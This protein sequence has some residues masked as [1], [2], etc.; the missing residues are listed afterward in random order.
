MATLVEA[1][2]IESPRPIITAAPPPRLCTPLRDIPFR[3]LPALISNP[4]HPP[5][6]GFDDPHAGID[7]AVMLPDSQVAIAGHPVQAALSGRVAMLIADRF[8]FGNALLIETPLD[9]Q[10]EDW[11]QPAEV[12]TPAPTVG[13]LSALTCPNGPE[14]AY[15][16]PNHRS[17]YILY[18]H[19]QQLPA[20]AIDD[21][22][23]CGQQIGTVGSSGNSLN[24]HL[25]FETRAAPAGIRL[26][27][28]AHYHASVNTEEMRAYCLWSVSGLFQ[29]V[30]PQ[31]VLGLAP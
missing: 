5:R 1:A 30:D 25:H 11:W 12:P 19:L 24:P 10:P 16:D 28:M 8:P 9:A 3:Q 6:P 15:A 26:A 2:V 4:Y 18:A 20:L 23:S 17:M 7:L 29:L 14:P 13:S 31:R 21:L 22:V 27:G